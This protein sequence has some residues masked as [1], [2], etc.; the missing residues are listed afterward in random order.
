MPPTTINP[1]T[2]INVM[3]DLNAPKTTKMPETIKENY[4][5]N[6]QLRTQFGGRIRLSDEDRQILRD[7]Y[8]K[9]RNAESPAESKPALQLTYPHRHPVVYAC[10]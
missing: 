4:L 2:G 7:A 5:P 9:A 10:A 1:K 8:S 6:G 3:P